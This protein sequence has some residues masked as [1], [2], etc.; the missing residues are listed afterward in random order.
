MPVTLTYTVIKGDG[1]VPEVTSVLPTDCRTLE[2]IFSKA[3]VEVEA[4]DP[5][6]YATTPP[7]AIKSVQKVGDR[8][9]RLKTSKQDEL[10]SY[11]ITVS[12]V[13]DLDGNLI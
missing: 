12:N 1:S 7:L 13:H 8:R 11:L 2:A 5:G 9:Y 10:V 6:N 4:L 3:V